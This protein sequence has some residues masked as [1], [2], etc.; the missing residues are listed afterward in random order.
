[1]TNRDG[2]S[3]IEVFQRNGDR[4]IVMKLDSVRELLIAPEFDPFSDKETEFMGQSAMERLIRQLKPG[5]SL[6]TRNVRLTIMLPADQITPETQSQIRGSF[7]RFC[8]KKIEENTIQL[9]NIRWSGIRQI[10]FSFVF[11]AVCIG[12]GTLFGSGLIPHI[13][14]WLGTV[15]NEGFYI[16]GWVSLWGPTETLLF[17]PQPLKRENKIL[18]K[19]VSIPLD[20]QPR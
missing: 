17:D 1:V 4:H 12:L 3:L 5:W 16:I 2:A 19:L 15:L 10:P 7:E 14:A 9:R 20:I 6:H 18:N 8:R 13:P 11:L